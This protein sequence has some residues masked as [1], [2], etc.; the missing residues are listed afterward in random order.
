MDIIKILN[1]F[2]KNEQEDQKVFRKW[3]VEY[4]TNPKHAVATLFRLLKSYEMVLSDYLEKNNLA[5]ADRQYIGNALE[6]IRIELEIIRFRIHN[7]NLTKEVFAKPHKRTSQLK[8]TGN[9]VD[10]VE[11]LYALHAVG[12]INGGQATLA[13]L[14]REMG[15]SFDIDVK[16]YSSYFRNIKNR[17]ERTKFL[18][19]LRR[20][21]TEKMDKMDEK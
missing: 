10:F 3:L 9:M 13:E 18:D 19:E 8:W 4:C 15:E 5:P 1:E 6:I 16:D 12:Y 2:S 21:L 14:F 11:L 7:I 20:V 17:A